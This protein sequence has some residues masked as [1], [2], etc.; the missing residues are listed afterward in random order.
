[1]NLQDKMEDRFAWEKGDRL[2]KKREALRASCFLLPSCLLFL[3]LFSF[4]FFS[5][6]FPSGEARGDDFKLIPSLSFKEEYNDNLFFTE[7]DKER[8]LITTISPGLE[9][10]NRTEK[11]DLNLSGRIHKLIY[12][13]ND[14]LG[15]VEQNYRGRLRYFLHPKLNLFAE[16]GFLRDYRTDRDIEITGLVMKAIRR[17][18]QNYGAGAE[19]IFSEKTKGNFFYSF[20]RSDYQRDPEFVDT[21]YHEASIG[22]IHDFSQR[23]PS[24]MGRINFGYGRYEYGEAAID[25]YYA[26]IGMSRQISEKWSVLVDGGGSYTH[27]EFEVLRAIG[28]PPLIVRVKKKEDGGGWVGQASLSYRGEKTPRGEKTA[29]DL[30]FSHRMMPATGTIGATQRTTLLLDL[31]H[32]FTYELLA[33]LSA[34]YYI[35]KSERERFG[36]GVLDERTFRVHPRIRYEFTKDMAMEGS[37]SF[38]LLRNR[39]AGTT[40]KRNLFMLTFTIQYPLFE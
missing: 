5:L 17:D 22:F 6:V 8:D 1:M 40:V 31:S 35:N 2:G 38:T 28:L 13:K 29:G 33:R 25:Y 11:L 30:T 39:D 20:E 21:N 26:T 9:L 36:A 15:K 24:T 18:R 3:F 10:I 27:S 32:R 23:L 7:T 19:Y 37:Y 14:P 34:G 4:F 12:G 16:A